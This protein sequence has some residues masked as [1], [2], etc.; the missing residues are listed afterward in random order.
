M[1]NL[2]VE[3]VESILPK[4]VIVKRSAGDLEELGGHLKETREPPRF[5]LAMQRPAR[6]SEFLLFEKIEWSADVDHV[7]FAKNDQRWVTFIF[8]KTIKPDGSKGVRP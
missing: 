7:Y 8:L 1:G 6:R 5:A 4:E 2:N 3:E